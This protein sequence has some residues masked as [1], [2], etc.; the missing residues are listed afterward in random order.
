[1]HKKQIPDSENSLQYCLVRELC[2]FAEG[3]TNK[4]R[5]SKEADGALR[6]LPRRSRRLSRR[7]PC[8]FWAAGPSQGAYLQPQRL[9]RLPRGRHA[10]SAHPAPYPATNIIISSAGP[11]A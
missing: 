8:A 7:P 9:Q 6:A 4:K 5:W 2:P 11:F 1:M 3:R 10:C